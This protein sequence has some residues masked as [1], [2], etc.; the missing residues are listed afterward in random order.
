MPYASSTD[1]FARMLLLCTL[2]YQLNGNGIIDNLGFTRM[3]PGEAI[4]SRTT[5]LKNSE[6]PQ[7]DKVY[8]QP[9]SSHHPC[10]LR[11]NGSIYA[12]VN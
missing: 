7:V 1:N 2:R 9:D 8:L 4:H 5:L 3:L 12:P 10:C 11:E 6:T